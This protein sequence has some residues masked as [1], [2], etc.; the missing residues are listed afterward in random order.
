MTDKEIAQRA[1]IAHNDKNRVTGAFQAAV[2]DI[3][4]DGMRVT[5]QIKS[6]LIDALAA[7]EAV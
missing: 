1:R 4:A 7:L 3:R 5:A 2:D 6:K